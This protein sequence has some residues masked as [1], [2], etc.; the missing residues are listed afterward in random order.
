M[1]PIIAH[2]RSYL[3]EIPAISR[4]SLIQ[5]LIFVTTP[6]IAMISGV[7]KK[8]RPVV[9]DFVRTS[10]D[11]GQI[12]LLMRDLSVVDDDSFGLPKLSDL[13]ILKKSRM[14]VLICA[15]CRRFPDYRSSSTLFSLQPR[16]SP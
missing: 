1:F 14:S 4:L 15:K 12:A 3:G 9:R 6:E 16:K 5:H 11:I 2:E 7:F 10:A 8:I 13:M